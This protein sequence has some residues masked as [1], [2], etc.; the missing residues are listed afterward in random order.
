MWII[1]EL[2][3][4]FYQ[5]FLMVYFV[6]Q[7]LEAQVEEKWW[8]IALPIVMAGSFLCMYLFYTTNIPDTVIFVIPFFY[9]VYTR[10][11]T[12]PQRIFW[13]LILGFVFTAVTTLSYTI[14][15][16]LMGVSEAALLE[17]N[18]VRLSYVITTNIAI[19]IA[20]SLL[21][22]IGN[23]TYGLFLSRFSA[24]VFILLLMLQFFA[25]EVMY[26]YITG[27]Q[28]NERLL[29]IVNMGILLMAVFTLLLYEIMIRAARNKHIVEMKLQTALMTQQHQTEMVVIYNKMLATQHD[30]RQQINIAK[31][32][33]SNKENE[34]EAGILLQN[35]EDSQN[36]I[37]TG[38]AMVDAILTAKKALAEQ[39]SI[40]FQY[41]PYP[42]QHLPIDEAAFGVLLSNILDNAI[43][44]AQ[45]IEDGAI[46]RYVSLRF[47]RSWDMF[48]IICKNSMNPKTV[49]KNGERFITSKSDRHLH[50][51]GVENIKNTVIEHACN[52]LSP[53]FWK[54]D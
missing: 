48:Y 50:G 52:T 33:L 7:R 14:H 31:Q 28:Q 1:F 21:V 38:C 54:H 49:K 25:I 34:K 30:L 47:A 9:I 45:R 6:H 20:L 16:E 5:G 4:N 53:L 10:R 44:A 11:G 43:E 2:I 13:T 15:I 40:E 3:I 18:S 29:V 37:L 46:V 32:M 17:S 51:F 42:L 12:W 36:G 19:T 23:N 35:A 8:M 24:I 39:V 26:I 27:R 22:R 41:E